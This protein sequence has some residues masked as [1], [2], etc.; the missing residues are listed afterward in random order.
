[1]IDSTHIRKLNLN[2]RD[3][4]IAFLG[5]PLMSAKLLEKLHDEGFN[6]V[7]SVAQPAKAKGRGNK[8]IVSEVEALS[9]K[10]SIPCFT[11]R[12]IREDY[13]FI[14][15]YDIDLIVCLAYG[16]IIPQGLIDSAKI[17]A[18]NFHGSILP[19]LRGADPIRRS[20]IE[21]FKT[22][23]F[24]L[25]EMVDKMDA[26]AV[27][28][29][30]EIDIENLNYDELVDA[31]TS[32]LLEFAPK[33]LKRFIAGE[34]IP[35]PQKEEEVTFAP[36]IK[37]E[38]EKLDLSLDTMTF[39]R[40]VLALSYHPGGFLILDDEPLKIL[41]ATYHSEKIDSPVGTIKA[42]AKDHFILQLK[43]GDISIYEIQKAGGKKMDVRAFLNGHKN[44]LGKILR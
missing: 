26:G 44:L 22:T 17:G 21:G 23:G 4:R 20:I 40:W 27:Y 12:K 34:L 42:L 5:S 30:F 35:H 39:L 36:K 11:P 2:Y 31:L 13:S 19:K 6:I 29:T 14:K 16:Q 41:K 18:L 43:D 15:D 28:D 24:S 38:D 9:K 8:V 3:V 25:M 10:L 7:L 32:S 37:K 1:M 33:S